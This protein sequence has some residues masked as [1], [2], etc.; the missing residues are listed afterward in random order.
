MNMYLKK[1]ERFLTAKAS[2]SKEKKDDRENIDSSF[3]EAPPEKK[4]KQMYH[5]N[6][7]WLVDIS[8]KNWISKREQETGSFTAF[9]KICNC[10]ILNHRPALVKHQNTTKHKQNVTAISKTTS[11]DEAFKPKKEEE[12][13]KRAEIKLCA[14]LAE[15]NLP[16]MLSDALVPFLANTF[17]DSAIIKSVN[18]GRTKA[19]NIVKTVLGPILTEELVS[20]LKKT[21]FSIIM[22][23]TTDISVKKQCALAVIFFDEDEFLVHTQFLDIYEVTSG[24]AKDL[25]D[26][27]LNWL[28]N[29]Q[30]P[31]KN[32][33]GFAS[34]TTNSMVGQH[35]S[36]FSH[37]KDRIPHI[38]CVKCSCHMIHLVASKAC[39]KLPRFVEDFLRNVGSHF[40]RSSLRQ[41]KLKELQIFFNV[42]VHK[43][44]SP[45]IT[46]WLSLQ[47]C[48]NRVLEQYDVLSEY[49]RLEVL[50]DPSKITE[51]I[52]GVLDNK[53][54]KVYL[55]FMSY[56]L[57]QFNDFNRLFQSEKPLLHQVKPET[58]K[59][60]KSIA[61]NYMQFNYCKTT[62]AFRL[63]YANPGFFVP[64][65]KIYLGVAA[66]SSIEELS[67]EIP[68]PKTEITDFK[69]TCLMFYIES[70][71]QI[72]QRFDF[73]DPIYGIIEVIEPS[74]AQKFEIKDLSSVLKRFS[75]LKE[76]VNDI[77]LQ[78]EW[79]KH[80]FLEHDSNLSQNVEQ[81]WRQILKMKDLSGSPI[82]P[83]LKKVIGLLLVL[84]FS[85]ASVERIFSQL[86]LI[87]CDNRNRLNT[88]TISALMATKANI[89]NA[90]EFEPSK[91]MML[92]KIT[93]SNSGEGT[94]LLCTI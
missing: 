94:N 69:R 87:K 73:S 31:L 30:I 50:E 63:E 48:V 27:L 70:I 77:E 59:L 39:L 22:D 35:N 8:F 13:K 3:D 64:L 6:E 1:M 53:L 38:A 85:N 62:D 12:L 15:H 92:K 66:Q 78:N 24:K 10:N 46:R 82:F 93:Y 23:E 51:D 57:D 75:N 42:D 25:T 74:V 41:E 11:I 56:V 21:T 79:K 4:K 34:D 18:L 68:E 86:K 19:T 61:S 81:Y 44:L 17:P 43:I 65:E 37:L 20:K 52:I 90:I 47:A 71:K 84:P 33:V 58:Q 36:V 9:C 40:S 16:L 2:T 29:K 83:N 49:F 88:Q 5:F 91:A 60:I 80:A 54:T 14:F 45:S 67:K 28:T 72:T 55:E 89:Q 32:F 7:K 76:D 26:A